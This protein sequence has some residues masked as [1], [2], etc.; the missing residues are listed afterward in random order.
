MVY[1]FSDQVTLVWRNV[2]VT[3]FLCYIITVSLVSDML[4][5]MI[6]TRLLC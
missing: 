4:H 1:A 2:Y 5:D 3:Q 6:M